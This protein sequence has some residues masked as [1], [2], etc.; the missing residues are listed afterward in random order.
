MLSSNHPKQGTVGG[1]FGDGPCRAD[2]FQG[3]Y[4][5]DK[6]KIGSGRLRPTLL[7]GLPGV[8][9]DTPYG[10]EIKQ[11]QLN[12]IITIADAQQTDRIIDLLFPAD[13]DL[14]Q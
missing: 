1:L 11:N 12:A 13:C 14:T 10:A 4:T 5:M 8:P 9:P 3:G 7:P 2:N 6:N